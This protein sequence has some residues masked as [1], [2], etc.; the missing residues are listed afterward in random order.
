MKI[1]LN[2]IGV[3]TSNWLKIQLKEIV[4]LIKKEFSIYQR[5][6]KMKKAIDR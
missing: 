4:Y 3:F 6:R 5:E 2:E 1:N